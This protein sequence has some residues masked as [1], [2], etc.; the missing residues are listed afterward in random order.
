MEDKE[1]SQKTDG[2]L[3]GFETLDELLQVHRP[4]KSSLLPPFQCSALSSDLTGT[5]KLYQELMVEVLNQELA[6]R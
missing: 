3:A 5:R 1:E 2:T 6:W 4:P